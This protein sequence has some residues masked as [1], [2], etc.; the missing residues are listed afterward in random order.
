MAMRS[1]ADLRGQPCK[2]SRF[3]SSNPISG[4]FAPLFAAPACPGI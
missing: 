2:L 1:S 3:R 4:S